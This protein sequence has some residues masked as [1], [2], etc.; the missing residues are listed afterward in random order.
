MPFVRSPRKAPAA[1]AGSSPPAR[2]DEAYF[3]R[4]YGD[5]RTRVQ[6]P[7]EVGHLARAVSS[8]AAFWTLP[9]ETALDVGAGAGL[10]RDALL[11]DRPS[12][13]YRGVDL[14]PVA[15]ARYGHEAR[16][17]SRWRAPDR[18]DLV[19]CQG[20]LQY[21]DDKDAEAAIENL[22]AMA[23]GLLYLEAL[24]RHDADEVVDLTRSDVAVHLRTGAW[25]RKRLA[26]KFREVGCGLY[27]ARG[28]GGVFFE[29]EAADGKGLAPNKTGP[30]TAMRRAPARARDGVPS[31][32][33]EIASRPTKTSSPPATLVSQ[34]V[35]MPSS[36]TTKA[37]GRGPQGLRRHVQD[38]V[39]GCT[40]PC[41]GVDETLWRGVRGLV[42][43]GTRPC[44]GGH[45]ALW[46]GA[47]DLRSRGR[48]L[49]SRGRDRRSRGGD[50][51]SRGGDRRSRG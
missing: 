34:A 49:R 32:P 44:G 28:A 15:C 11:R 29:L 30:S 27:Y 33:A 12:L 45:E 41:G 46:R 22:G 4:Y 43:G 17:I 18:F 25:Y 10:W 23:G 24:T 37:L 16:D 13:R 21:L 36:P 2:F 8:L 39:E 26:R 35:K 7:D 5:P 14:S 20:V 40:R 42:E 38:L 47:R 51:R 31:R 50:R 19:I 48:D 9:L 3:D 1:P 6:G